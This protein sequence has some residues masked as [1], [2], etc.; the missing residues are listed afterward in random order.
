[1]NLQD[2]LKD[3]ENTINPRATTVSQEEINYVI[4]LLEIDKTNNIEELTKMRNGLFDYFLHY[5][6]GS[7]T[8]YEALLYGIIVYLDYEMGVK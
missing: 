4:E 6:I 5:Y 2:K 3:I 7:R 1:M 8:I